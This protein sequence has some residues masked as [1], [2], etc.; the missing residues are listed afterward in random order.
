[1]QSLAPVCEREAACV[2]NVRRLSFL[3]VFDLA[4]LLLLLCRAA[5]ADDLSH[6]RH[7][8]QLKGEGRGGMFG[9]S[10][11]SE[12]QGGDGLCLVR[13]CPASTPVPLSCV[14]VCA[15]AASFIA[16]STIA[17]KRKALAHFSSPVDPHFLVI[18]FYYDYYGDHS[19]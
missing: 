15:L 18:H 12:E 13:A 14:R 7:G 17:A 5:A 3:Y 1:M 19:G 9:R 16:I 10:R 4:V 11:C 8:M 6:E 2:Y